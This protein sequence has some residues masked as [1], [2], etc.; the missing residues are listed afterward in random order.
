MGIREPT[1]RRLHDQGPGSGWV[2]PEG[3]TGRSGRPVTRNFPAR[4]GLGELRAPCLLFYSSSSARVGALLGWRAQLWIRFSQNTKPP[5]WSLSPRHWALCQACAHPLCLCQ[6]GGWA[7]RMDPV[8]P[9]GLNGGGWGGVGT[10]ILL[11]PSP[12]ILL[13]KELLRLRRELAPW[14]VPWQGGEP[15]TVGALSSV[16]VSFL[17]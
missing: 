5:A 15:L 6:G 17:D 2:R 3:T 16:H 14:R 10:L 1:C 4:L 12:A 7:G 9:A 11:K 13:G 8:A